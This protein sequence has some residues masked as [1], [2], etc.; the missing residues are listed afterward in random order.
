[1]NLWLNYNQWNKIRESDKLFEL[2]YSP[3]HF[4][5]DF[6]KE[7][8]DVFWSIQ[9][10]IINFSMKL[11]LMQSMNFSIKFLCNF[12]NILLF[13]QKI[14]FAYVHFSQRTISTNFLRKKKKKCSINFS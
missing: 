2:L 4:T 5:S 14:I 3:S 1:M 6:S 11:N 7:C 10:M 9:F 12:L 8:Y 13:F